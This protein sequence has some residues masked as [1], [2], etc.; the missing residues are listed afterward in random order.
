MF[1]IKRETFE[2]AEGLP[3]YWDDVAG[4]NIFL[5]RY[6]LNMLHKT[7]PCG[8]AY[9][10]FYSS[11]PDS[12][13]VTYKLKLDIFTYNK[14]SFKLPVTIV[15]IPC[16]VSKC[17]YKIGEETRHGVNEFLKNLQGFKLILNSDNLLTI[18]SFTAGA[19]LPTCKLDIC[20]NNFEHYLESF[21]SHYRYRI[22]KAI[23]KWHG[24]KVIELEHSTL[25][26][27]NLY[28]LYLQVYNKSVYKLEK[29][30]MDFFKTFP[31]QIIKFTF[32]GKDLAFV[33]LLHNNDEL[34]FLL[35]GFDYSSNLKYDIYVNVLLEIV[36]RGIKGNFN[37]IDMGQT[38]E[39]TKMKL[40]CQQYPKGL[41]ASHSGKL[42]NLLVAK[43]ITALSY[44]Q[45]ELK[46]N[47]FKEELS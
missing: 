26:D 25:F 46:F 4:E 20:W 41:Y 31:A 11:V 14:F 33:Q 44:K 21:R 23:K 1:E 18:D 12:I 10:I 30:E 29:L 5:K 3:V 15:G 13:I 39:E 2:D 36:K 34:I 38:A 42:L 9:H 19:T 45:K 28:R 43:S 6:S 27:E 7:N 24:V 40:G 35:G 47:I 16:S 37:V 22:N 8:Q 32:E 17:G